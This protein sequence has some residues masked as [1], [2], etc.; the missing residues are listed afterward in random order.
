MK[1]NFK[2]MALLFVKATLTYHS[3][4]DESMNCFKYLSVSVGK[5]GCEYSGVNYVLFLHY[6]GCHAQY[7]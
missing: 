5:I 3:K 2:R 1:I 7:L 4:A 6:A